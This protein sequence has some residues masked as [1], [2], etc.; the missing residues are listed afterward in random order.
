M[1]WLKCNRKKILIM[2]V[3]L[4]VIVTINDLFITSYLN[5]RQ[6]KIIGN[7]C[8]RLIDV[9]PESERTIFGILKNSDLYQ[10]L[11]EDNNVL[12][13]YGYSSADFGDNTF[14]II[15]SILCV[16]SGIILVFLIQFYKDKRV[17][18]RINDIT[19]YLEKVNAG[20]QGIILDTIEDEFSR[21]QDELYKTVVMLS[22]TRAPALVEKSNY[23]DNLSNIA[24]QLKTPITSISLSTQMMKEESTKEHVRQIK[25]QVDRLSY[26]EESLLL[27]A[28]ID[29]GTL[30]L[31]PAVTDIFWC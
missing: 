6:F 26:L 27:L 17:L 28:R 7:L 1:K 8:E 4:F 9:E 30:R 22:Q 5:N 15:I 2:A 20:N 12:L 19:G 16:L 13:N 25:K 11:D 21:L 24:H 18:S 23:A 10:N 14:I 3:I 31:K 29:A